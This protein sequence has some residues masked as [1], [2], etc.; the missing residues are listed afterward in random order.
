MKMDSI[1]GKQKPLL[2]TVKRLFGYVSQL[3]TTSENTPR[4]IMEGK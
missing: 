3:Y 4:G 1:D 2:S